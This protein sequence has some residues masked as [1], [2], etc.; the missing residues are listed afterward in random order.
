MTR[1]FARRSK[2]RGI[3][4]FSPGFTAI[5][6]HQLRI[7]LGVARPVCTETFT[8]QNSSAASFS[9]AKIPSQL[10]FGRN[11]GIF[12]RNSFGFFR[13]ESGFRSIEILTDFVATTA[14]VIFQ[15]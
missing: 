10:H 8:L 6:I 3:V 11:H 1:E 12:E 14:A 2:N 15:P 13:A 5:G 4:C 7:P 9:V